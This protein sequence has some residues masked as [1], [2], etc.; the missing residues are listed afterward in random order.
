MLAPHY[1]EQDC[2]NIVNEVLDHSPFD[3]RSRYV[4]RC[5]LWRE[6]YPEEPF[7]IDLTKPPAVVTNYQS[8]IRYNLEEACSR[9]F[10][11][12]YQV[13]LPHY[14]DDLFL[15]KAVE[16]YE[17]YLRIKRCHP[18]VVMV[19]SHDVELI[20][21]AH[22][23]HPLNYRQTTT[24]LLGKP[25][26]QDDTETG[27]TPGSTLYESE[28]TARAASVWEEEG[29]RFA[30]SGAAYRGDPP[31]P[32]PT[33]PKFLYAPLALSEYPCEIQGIEALELEDEGFGEQE[34]GKQNL[35][36]RL[37]DNWGK[38]YFSQ[39]FKGTKAVSNPRPW[40]FV[41]ENGRER[42]INIYVCLYKKKIFGEE[43]IA[44]KKELDLCPQFEAISFFDER[45]GPR[46]RFTVHVV[47]MFYKQVASSWKAK[48]K[49]Q[50]ETKYPIIVK[51][52]FEVRPNKMFRRSDHPSLILSSPLLM[53]SPSDLA[54]PDVPCD[55]STHKVIDSRGNKTFHCRVVHS[56]AALL[57]AAEVID[58]SDQV[59]ATTHTI[60]PSTLPRMDDVEDHKNSIVLNQEEGERAM[61]IRGNQ[62]W[63]VCIGHWQRDSKAAAMSK[64]KEQYFVGI[65]VFKLSGERGWCSVRKSSGGVFHIKVDS[66]TT[67]TIDLKANK[68]EIPPQAHDIPE[69]L[70]LAF[71]L[72]I[73][74][75]LFIPYL[76][77]DKCRPASQTSTCASIPSSFH[78]AGYGSTNVPTNAYLGVGNKEATSENVTYGCSDF[79]E[80]FFW[81]ECSQYP[82][83]S[84]LTRAGEN[85]AGGGYRRQRET[86]GGGGYRERR[87]YRRERETGGGG[88]YRERRGSGGSES[89][90][91]SDR[92][93]S[94][95]GGGGWEGLERQ[96]SG[97]SEGGHGCERTE[98][99]GG[100]GGWGYSGGG[101]SGGGF[102]GGGS[103]VGGEG[104]DGGYED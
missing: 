32:M 75:L 67:V 104:C 91:G 44:F 48:V 46:K 10:K 31:D 13:S 35:I 18:D 30:K 55:S 59:V 23:L 103:I 99:Y 19:P 84:S 29:L 11:F 42:D 24:E 33:P 101:G 90:H 77:Y 57:S 100:G 98:S 85:D 64:P 25:L 93:E 43:L 34:F 69:V 22:Q 65:K 17:H 47:L 63:A 40:K 38:K 28:M 86:G 87:G 6:A 20:W 8:K 60:S 12:F 41:F 73:L 51:Y 92:R 96:D 79:N 62:D 3:V 68:V 4:T 9:Q 66:V 5:D 36:V 80:D 15:K 78:S 71:S 95:G 76:S 53:L 97:G 49:I 81:N 82:L 72:S 7:E 1:Y 58:E 26:H 50:V 89:G 94:N 45:V 83:V 16:R 21:H 37:E 2:L 27:R 14:R 54:R 102:D 70:A 56:S 74:H 88:G 39:S 52:N 61:L